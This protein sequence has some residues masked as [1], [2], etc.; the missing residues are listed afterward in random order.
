M[1][2]RRNRQPRF[3]SSDSLLD[4]AAATLDLHGDTVATAKARVAQFLA[5]RVR[6]NPGSLVHI[7]TGTGKGSADGARLR[8]MVA[9][10][11][12]GECARFVKEWDR[13]VDDGGFR[14]RLR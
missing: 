4:G 7:I 9:G 3:D 10:L 5:S 6:A 12:K 11:L 1:H 8:P 14:V 13:D 2:G